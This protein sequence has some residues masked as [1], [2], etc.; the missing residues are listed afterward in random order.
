MGIRIHKVLGYGLTDF[1]GFEK[2]PR[3]NP[4]FNYNSAEENFDAEKFKKYFKQRYLELKDIREK[5]KDVYAR[6]YGFEWNHYFRKET[7]DKYVADGYSQIDHIDAIKTGFY[8]HNSIC[9]NYFCEESDEPYPICFTTPI[10][11]DWYRYD[12]IIDY[13]DNSPDDDVKLLNRPIYPHDG[14]EYIKD[15]SR[16]RN[17]HEIIRHINYLK[18]EKYVDMSEE[19]LHSILCNN[20]ELNDMCQHCVGVNYS[21]FWDTVNFMVAP[22]VYEYLRFTGM[23]INEQEIR[24]LKPMIVTY[25]S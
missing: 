13:Y 17:I 4:K 24:K 10:Y 11:S 3:I 23:F 6:E 1:L 12:D 21:E 19:E 18:D 7:Y 20:T 8:F 15:G 2:D 25:W 14:F 22:I 5:T 9:Y 16:A